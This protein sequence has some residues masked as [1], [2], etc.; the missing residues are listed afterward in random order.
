MRLFFRFLQIYREHL[1]ETSLRILVS[2]GQKNDTGDHKKCDIS[3]TLFYVDLLE[4][5]TTVDAK[6]IFGGESKC[7]CTNMKTASSIITSFR[8][9]S[10]LHRLLVDDVRHHSLQLDAGWDLSGWRL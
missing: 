2:P 10:R 5:T 7:L 6:T 8:L 3:D 1:L 4:D 9:P